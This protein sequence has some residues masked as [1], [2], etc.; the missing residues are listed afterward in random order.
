MSKTVLVTGISGFIG[1][2]CVKE[3]LNKG[4]RV[5]GTVRNYSKLVNIPDTQATG[6]GRR[7]ECMWI[8]FL[9]DFETKGK[10]FYKR[11]GDAVDTPTVWTWV[12]LCPEE[13][14]NCM[15]QNNPYALSVTQFND[16]CRESIKPV[17][18]PS[19]HKLNYDAVWSGPTMLIKKLYNAN[20]QSKGIDG[21]YSHQSINA[22]VW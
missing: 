15:E 5:K 10:K 12:D 22:D 7:D 8:R 13:R 6:F 19:F 17:N 20:N 21:N 1:L 18:P 14:L 2:Y 16:K 3:L 9:M 11:N 4:Y